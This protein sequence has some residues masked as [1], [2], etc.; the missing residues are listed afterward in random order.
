MFASTYS[1]PAAA[2]SRPNKSRIVEQAEF[3]AGTHSILLG[4]S[5][6]CLSALASRGER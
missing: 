2:A 3:F 6:C 5:G 4:S 1:T